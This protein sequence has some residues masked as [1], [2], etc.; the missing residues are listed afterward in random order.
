MFPT[1]RECSK[2]RFAVLFGTLAWAASVSAAETTATPAA[3]KKIV[4]AAPA[5]AVKHPVI[6]KAPYHARVGIKPP[7]KTA[8][9]PRVVAKAGAEGVDCKP[10]QHRD[11]ANHQK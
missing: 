7:V 9:V 2:I 8:A 4:H 5:S 3:K 10:R 11:K 6:A 1:I